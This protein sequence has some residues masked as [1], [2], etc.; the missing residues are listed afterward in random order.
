MNDFIP[1][2]TK[3]NGLPSCGFNSHVP[4][5]NFL[6]FLACAF[7]VLFQQQAIVAE[8]EFEK[9]ACKASTATA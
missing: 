8:S 9:H 7:Y 3:L 1:A 5:I 6:E 2:V 4:D